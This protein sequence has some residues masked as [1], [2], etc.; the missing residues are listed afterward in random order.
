[1]S[2]TRFEQ[3]LSEVP[4]ERSPLRPILARDVVADTR[5][6][7]SPRQL[8]GLQRRAG[9][10]AVSR[11]LQ[12]S[13]TPTSYPWIGRIKPWS[14]ALRAAPSKPGGAKAKALADLPRGSEVTVVNRKSGWLAVQATVGGSRLDGYV[15]RELVEFDHASAF[16]LGEVV[17]SVK[18]PTVAEAFVA[19]KRLETR[20]AA[21]GGVLELSEDEQS[22]A[23]LAI[24]VLQK[25]GKY[26]V[27]H[28][29]F[30]VSFDR[31]KATA[32][33]V[34][35]LEDFILFVEEVERAFPTAG[36]A[37]IASE[38]R[39]IWYS[40]ENWD[41]LSAGQGIKQG[42]ALVDIE[43]EAPV[44]TAFD[45]KQIAP[46]KGSLKLVTP[47]GRVDIGHVISGID[48]RLN[49]SPSAY[50]ESY[51]KKRDHDTYKNK[52]KYDAMQ[53]ASGG[54]T[55]D[56]ATWSG[57]LG[58]AYAEYIADRY[59]NQNA[60]ATLDASMTT[61]ATD[62]E[63]RG[64]IHGYI[65]VQVWTMLPSADSPTGSSQKVSNILRDMYLSKPGTSYRTTLT[66]QHITERTLAFARLWYSKLAYTKNGWWSSAGWGPSEILKNYRA[67]FDGHHATNESSAAAKDKLE[68]IVDAFM[69]R[70]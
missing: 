23:D 70:L 41:V 50:P 20:K 30:S 34:H 33:Q 26:T 7:A 68:A 5:L 49:G 46:A 1:V 52:A 44:A 22:S 4:A 69:T 60:A 11:L 42:G 63:L 24:S 59:L 37:E 65:A 9:N 35:T 8:L 61:W 28:T 39:Q 13:S 2:G 57:D 27:N 15:S 45:M 53:A 56:F 18:V 58:Q 38:I 47:V 62:E 21:A 25:T 66:K 48:V 51:M 16:D 19:L 29:T 12:R 32:V 3:A 43:T 17:V 64:D 40:D 55:T 14:A 54:D 36:P 31:S 10:R 67:E 6:P